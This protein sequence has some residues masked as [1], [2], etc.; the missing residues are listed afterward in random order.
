MKNPKILSSPV[1]LEDVREYHI[2][3]IGA[4][5][6]CLPEGSLVSV[7][8][9]PNTGALF[10]ICDLDGQPATHYLDGQV[11]DKTGLLIGM[12]LLNG[13]HPGVEHKKG[14]C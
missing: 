5:F 14:E 6:T 10:V 2:L 11:D 7:H 13:Q 12:E 1:K 3:R 9:D 4:G 8:K